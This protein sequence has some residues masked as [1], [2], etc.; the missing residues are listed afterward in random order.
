MALAPRLARTFVGTFV[1]A[2]R[3]P[4]RRVL[5]YTIDF[6]LTLRRDGR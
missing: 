5:T 2:G 4:L 6:R 3:C 1:A